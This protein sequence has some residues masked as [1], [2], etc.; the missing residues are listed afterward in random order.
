V[1]GASAGH[2]PS[3]KTKSPGHGVPKPPYILPRYTTL[4]DQQKS[5]VDKK[6]GA[7]MSKIPIYVAVMRN[8]NTVHSSCLLVSHHLFCSVLGL[9]GN[10]HFIF[11]K[12]IPHY[13]VVF[14]ACELKLKSSSPA[15]SRKKNLKNYCLV[16]LVVLAKNCC[17]VA[18]VVLALKI[19]LHFPHMQSG[20]RYRLREKVSSTR[21]PDYE[22][23]PPGSQQ[24]RYM[25]GCIPGQGE[26][27]HP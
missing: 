17:L 1:N 22:A 21:E 12:F 4:N 25:G 2:A 24:G 20:I 11:Q 16:A 15:Y 7:I 23:L 14:G 10:W 18:L 26:E 9:K 27:I 19:L 3:A 5:E 13:L 6:V 8:S